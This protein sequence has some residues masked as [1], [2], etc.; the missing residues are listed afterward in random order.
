MANGVTD[1]VRDGAELQLSRHAGDGVFGSLNRV[2]VDDVDERYVTF[3]KRGLN[4]RFTPR[5]L[6]RRGDCVSSRSRIR[7]ET[8]SVSACA[9]DNCRNQDSDPSCIGERTSKEAQFLSLRSSVKPLRAICQALV[10]A[11]KRRSE[12][13]LDRYRA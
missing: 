9:K 13:F 3:R 2:F 4:L 10:L 8:I 1:L 12:R 11:Q 5:R 6:I 7:T